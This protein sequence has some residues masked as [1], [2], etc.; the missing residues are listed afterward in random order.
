MS[1]REFV[2]KAKT[3]VNQMWDANPTVEMLQ[4]IGESVVE[5]PLP[6]VALAPRSALEHA[7]NRDSIKTVQY[8]GLDFRTL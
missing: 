3:P 8:V 1:D 2:R 6:G 7:A 5:L 4:K